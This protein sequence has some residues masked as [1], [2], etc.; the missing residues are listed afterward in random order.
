MF[1]A[2]LLSFSR[3]PAA[4]AEDGLLPGALAKTNRHG[5][6]VL[7]VVA[8]SIVYSLGLFFDFQRLLELDVLF[9][10]TSIM[11]EFCALVA[12]RFKEPAL[13][14]PFKV[15][16]GV[17]FLILMAVGPGS[18]FLYALVRALTNGEQHT[19]SLVAGGVCVMAGAIVLVRGR[20]QLYPRPRP[21]PR[22][23]P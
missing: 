20:R 14:R 10:G 22:P 2:L 9:Y 7:A 23:R 1:N 16:G 19:T 17:P 18:L 15:P 12:L 3:L 21:R 4:M 11:L 13:E 6:P 5:V 8:C